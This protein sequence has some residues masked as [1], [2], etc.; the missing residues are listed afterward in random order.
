MDLTNTTILIT[1][2]GTGIGL[3]LAEAL[4]KKGNRIV[5][6]GRREEKLREAKA[7]IPSMEYSVTDLR[8]PNDLQAL[9]EWTT[10]QFPDVGVLVNNAGIQQMLDFSKPDS[11][12][13][14]TAEIE[15]N[16][17]APIV[18][19]SLFI[20]HFLRKE[21]SAIINV[22]SGLAFAPLAFLPVYC[23]TKAAMHSFSLSLRHQLRN[24]TIRVF[25]AIPPTVDTD[26]DK[27]AR[28][29]RGQKDRGIPPSVVAQEII[30]G[31][32]ADEFEILIGMAKNLRESG[33]KMFFNMNK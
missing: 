13:N 2:G 18:L 32:E 17:S 31:V 25:E 8:K 9:F 20:R 11:V 1:G 15:A 6:C 30:R 14:P 5:I 21:K 22:T 4:S 24:T 26:L 27:G 33:D 12:K 16:L 19:S 29:K 7:R 3:S 23:A 10:N 28:E